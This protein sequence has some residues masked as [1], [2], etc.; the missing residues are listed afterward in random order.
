MLHYKVLQILVPPV[1]VGDPNSIS[2]SKCL[3]APE[4][5]ILLAEGDNIISANEEN[6]ASY[7]WFPDEANQFTLLEQNTSINQVGSTPVN[8]KDLPRAY[9]PPICSKDPYALRNNPEHNWFYQTPSGEKCKRDT[10]VDSW[11]YSKIE[12]AC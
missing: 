9:P 4:H 11:S 3:I 6:G 5:V 12:E 10:S 7:E 1:Y 8:Q 2:G